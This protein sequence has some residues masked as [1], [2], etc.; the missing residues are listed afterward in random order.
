MLAEKRGKETAAAAAAAQEEKKKKSAALKWKEAEKP[1]A[2]IEI[3]NEL[4]AAALQNQVEFKK[5]ECQVEFKKE[6]WDK[7]EVADLSSDSYIKA[8]HRYF[9]PAEVPEAAAAAAA[10]AAVELL[11]KHGAQGALLYTVNKTCTV[12][13]S[14]QAREGEREREWEGE[15]ESC[16]VC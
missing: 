7:F 8:G 2:G 10:K 14:N 12:P 1:S 6:E 9:K 4:L 5:E 13:L 11:C 16:Q 15:K 3:K